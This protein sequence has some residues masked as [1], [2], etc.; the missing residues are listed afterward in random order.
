MILHIKAELILAHD[1]RVEVLVLLAHRR[2]KA[3]FKIRQRILSARQD[4]HL[5]AA[6]L[7]LP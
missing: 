5:I 4:K 2:R 6:V 7:I 1:G 3:E